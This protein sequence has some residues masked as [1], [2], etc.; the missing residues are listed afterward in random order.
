MTGEDICTHRCC[1]SRDSNP[2]SA[3][4]TPF[5]PDIQTRSR[6]VVSPEK[7]NLFSLSAVV[8]S[9]AFSAGSH[10]VRGSI[11]PVDSL[12][13]PT[14]SLSCK[15]RPLLVRAGDTQTPQEAEEWR[16]LLERCSKSSQVRFARI[17]RRYVEYWR[18][19]KI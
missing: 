5:L 6:S 11:L 2:F 4:S 1:S 15:S 14:V 7:L 8:A 13:L 12:L 9:C 16:L 17:C 10:P 18:C 3:A 19:Q